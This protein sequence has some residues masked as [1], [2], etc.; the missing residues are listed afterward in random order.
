MFSDLP[1]N[2]DNLIHQ[3]TIETTRLEFKKTWNEEIKKSVIRTVCAFA[4][5]LYNLNGGYIILG[6]EQDEQGKAILPPHGL[7]NLNLDKVQSEILSCKGFISPTCIPIVFSEIYQG[8]Q[9]L[10]LWVPAGDNRPYEAPKR[11][12]DGKAYYVRSIASTVEATGDLKRQLFEQASKIPFDDRR[13]LNVPIERISPQLIKEFLID[14]RSY[15]A[16]RVESFDRQDLYAKL[17]LTVPINSHS[18]P[19][20]VALLF[21]NQT[22]E[23]FFPGAYIEVVQF[24]D[25]AGGDLIEERE[26]KGPLPQQIT[27][28]LNNIKGLSG[29]LL[30]KIA[31]QAEVERTEAYPYEAIEEA[32]VNAVYH[33]G[34]DQPEPVK[35]YLYPERMEIISYPGP[36][37]GIAKHHFEP[38]NSIPPIPARNRRIGDFLKDL[39][40]AE[41]RGTGIPKILRKMSENGSLPPQFDFDEDHTYFIVTLSV[42]PRYQ[43]LHS[44]HESGQKLAT[45]TPRE[46]DIF[47]LLSEGN[48]RIQISE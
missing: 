33:K 1:I 13:S 27:S 29:R 16:E 36:V 11:S 25:D 19:K 34:Y 5:D 26:F 15:L 44:L 32:L 6:I 35:V 18:I 12:G 24:G 21:F 7:D 22:P 45:L 17:N 47:K 41:R 4:N 48:R 23:V 30:Q 9:I 14:I 42:H 8:K 3:R 43:V 38:N 46:L 10:I 37:K 20:N 39:Q 31:G 40:L 2:L 28:C